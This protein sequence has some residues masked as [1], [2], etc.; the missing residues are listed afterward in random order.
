M[1]LTDR[2]QYVHRLGRTARAGKSGSGL[3]LLADFEAPLLRDLKG[4]PLHPCTAT[5][6]ITGGAA[7]GVFGHTVSPSG[8]VRLRIRF[9]VFVLFHE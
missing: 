9:C 6:A 2:E 8:A 5:S 7:T 1:G 3:L 4:F